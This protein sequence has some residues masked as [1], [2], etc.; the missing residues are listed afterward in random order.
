M[1]VATTAMAVGV[2][3]ASVSGTLDPFV[4]QQDDIL[5]KGGE[6]TMKRIQET[7]RRR[8]M[9]ASVSATALAF[10]VVA[11]SAPA[12]AA[13]AAANEGIQIEEVVVTAQFREQKLQDTPIAITAV[14]AEL[15]AARSQTSI[16][17]I[18]NQAPNVM[19]KPQGGSFGP[20][21]GASIRGVGQFDF[22]PAYEPGVGLYVDDVYYPSLTGADMDLLDLERV[23]ILRGPQG[24]LTGRNSIGGA[25]KMISKKPTGSNTGY[26][27][28]TY[29]SDQRIGFRG[30]ADFA[31]ND[32]LDVRISG[33]MKK[34]NGYI[35]RIDYGCAFPTSGVPTTRTAGNCKVADDG[36]IGYDALRVMV[37]YRPNDRVD[38]NISADYT[39]DDR[40]MPG[41]VLTYANLNLASINPAPGVPYD[42][43]F[44]CG[45]Y[46]NYTGNSQPAGPWAGPVATGY[47]LKATSGSDHTVFEGQGAAINL[48]VDLTDNLKFESIS[49]Y[50]RYTTSFNSDDD[51]SPAYIGYGQNALRHHFFSQE[52][53]L[54]GK[55]NDKFQYTLG[56]YYSDQTT[57]YW[58]YQDIRY[59][60]IPLQFVGNDPVNADSKAVF[61]TGIWN[62]TDALNVTAGLR[63][64]EET[65]DYT[66][67]RLNPD[68]TNNP[69]LGALTGKVG[70]Y[71]GNNTDYRISVDYRWN[72]NLMTYAT[73]STGFKGGGVN[74]RPFNAAQVQPFGMEKLTAY[75]VGAKSDLLDGR[76]RAN[77]SAFFNKY[78]DMQIGVLSCPQFGGPGP[79]ALPMN[80]GDA[81]VKGVELEATAHVTDNFTIDASASYI[82]FKYKKL[83]AA[84]GLRLSDK[85]PMLPEW[86]WSL[87]AQYVFDFGDSGTFTPRVDVAYQDQVQTA[88]V[89]TARNIIPAYTVANARL[90]WKNKNKDL[91]A[92]LE[93]TNLTDKYYYLTKFD[94]TGAG[95]GFVKAQPA[96]PREVAFT[97]NKK[98]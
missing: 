62:V 17:D 81:D 43:R 47:P 86:K 93:V 40:T 73:I 84:T 35:S 78:Q 61:A 2:G 56:A 85:Q 97:V 55:L 5:K 66:Y 20:S 27:E 64:T 94:L 22:N 67:F 88:A 37:R 3:A 39:K 48:A 72:S 52:V 89:A 63:Y 38:L 14:N 1:R 79:C 15:M 51:L 50:R 25:I 91:D 69:F 33:A 28:A 8:A 26:V 76:L 34:Q 42:S 45:K 54:N 7:N 11:A 95:A 70:H 49:A 46:C 75:E 21:I 87:G 68:G 10:C 41:E 82:N 4:G 31:I 92:S 23:E 24:T 53:R 96:R 80:A 13:A 16:T 58:T 83:L 77:L 6:T 74:P 98:F 18:A 36:S 65:K 30:S 60:V 9:L 59:A 19:L 57:V 32:Q 12:M 29:G 90:T 71:A 44:I